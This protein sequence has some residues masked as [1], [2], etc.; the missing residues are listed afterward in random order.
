MITNSHLQPQSCTLANC[1]QLCRLKVREAQRGKVAI[2]SREG[3]EAV[4]DDREF[5]KDEGEC[6]AD[7]DEIRVAAMMSW[8]V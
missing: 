4:D 7:E 3:G 2:L 8:K 6:R 5:L 1:R